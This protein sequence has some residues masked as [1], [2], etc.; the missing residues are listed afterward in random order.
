M[1]RESVTF[2]VLQRIG[3]SFMFPIALLPVAGLLLG[4]GAS[5]TN[6]H[7]IA[8]FGLEWLLGSGTVLN[9]ILVVMKN[10]GD[11][12]F[13]NLP[14]IFAMGVALGMAEKEKATAA[15]SAAIAFLVMHKTISSMLSLSG[16]LES[17][18]MLVGQSK[19]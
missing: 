7:M 11:I 6:E 19:R 15:L 4:I 2:S 14:L 10:A 17:G 18:A 8:S 3:R 13:V 9:Y 16:K 5:F 1:K 12:V